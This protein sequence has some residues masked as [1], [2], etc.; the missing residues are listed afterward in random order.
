MSDTFDHEGDAWDSQNDDD[1]G[2]PSSH[3]QPSQRIVCY[4]CGAPC[5]WIQDKGKWQ[6]NAGGKRHV[7]PTKENTPEGFD[8]V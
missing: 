7:C 4:T 8:D 2:Y 3:R 1:F 6:L 5:Y